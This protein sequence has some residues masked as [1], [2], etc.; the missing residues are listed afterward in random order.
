MYITYV[1]EGARYIC[2]HTYTLVIRIYVYYI[3]MYVCMYVYMYIHAY[4]HTYI[5]IYIY[6]NIYQR[7]LAL[8]I[9]LFDDIEIPPCEQAHRHIPQ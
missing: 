9:H 2:I 3:C 5:Y 8:Y 1:V 7:A 6:M 4:I